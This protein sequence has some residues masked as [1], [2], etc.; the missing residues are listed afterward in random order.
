MVIVELEGTV[1]ISDKLKKVEGSV[2][3]IPVRFKNFGMVSY[4]IIEVV[5]GTW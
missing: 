3:G 5:K 1:I 4:I 2:G